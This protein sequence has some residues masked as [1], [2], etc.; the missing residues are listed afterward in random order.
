MYLSTKLMS[1]KV[2]SQET[3]NLVPT[4]AITFNYIRSENCFLFASKIILMPL[5]K[6]VSV[7]LYLFIL[8]AVLTPLCDVHTAL[9]STSSRDHFQ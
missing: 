6:Q 2:K 9:S 4:F 1:L 8:L 5:K 7:L 3:G